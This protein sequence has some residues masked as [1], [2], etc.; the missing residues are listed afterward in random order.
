MTEPSDFSNL[1][2]SAG[3]L[4][5]LASLQ[6]QPISRH[7]QL[8]RQGVNLA[9]FSLV[10]LVLL[11]LWLQPWHELPVT[12]MVFVKHALWLWPLL[13]VIRALYCWQADNHKHFALREH[14]IS[15]SSGIFFRKVIT[16]PV[17]RVQHIELKQGPLERKTELARLQLFSAGGALHTFEI[18]GLPLEQA[19][20]I[21]QFVLQHKDAQQDEQQ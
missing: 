12:S 2:L 1:Q 21:R 20:Q 9:V 15:Y 19:Q 3:Q 18:R 14:D 7:F 13:G 10:W 6:L 17:V 8:L 11:M 4:T 16:Q 5:P